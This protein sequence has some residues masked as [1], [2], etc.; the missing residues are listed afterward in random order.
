MIN[1]SSNNNYSLADIEKYLQ[2][3]MSAAEMHELEKAALQDAFLADAI[4]GYK[5]IS[6]QQSHQHLQ[7]IETLIIGTKEETKVIP[8]QSSNNHVWKIA[9]AVIAVALVGI[10]FWLTNS[11]QPNKNS[12]AVAKSAIQTTTDSS[13]IKSDTVQPIIATLSLSKKV[14]IAK[15]KVVDDQLNEL[16]KEKTEEATSLKKQAVSG[17]IILTDSISYL[18][19]AVAA[20]EIESEKPTGSLTID[21]AL[22]GK[23]AGVQINNK[24]KSKDLVIR[25]TSILSAGKNP[26]YIIDGQLYDNIPETLNTS[27]FKKIEVLNDAGTAALYGSRAANGVM[28]ITTNEKNKNIFGRITDTKGNPVSYASLLYKKD[29]AIATDA[30]GYFSINT[31]DTVL[32][33][34]ASA[35][36]YTA[37]NTQLANNRFNKIV[38]KENE[39]ALDEVVVVGYGT[40]KKMSL[41]GSVAAVNVNTDTLMPEGG[42]NNYKNYLTAKIT[43]NA[44]GKKVSGDI[45]FEFKIDSKGFAV[46]VNIL[47]SPDSSI[48]KQL[49]DAIK[50]GPK[51]YTANKKLKKQKAVIKL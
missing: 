27:A 33:L 12:V 50:Q 38:L 48:N 39:N 9:A 14:S 8:I 44:A 7:E 6:L 45:V 32:N 25:G 43:A 36:G 31:R 19:S 4:E 20:K 3:K 40:Q 23:V 11:N 37:A 30:N 21:Q 41:T 35:V 10:V 15:N 49:I 2:G 5:D 22:A 26:L 46:K 13:A 16:S 24:N 51:W 42:W 1:S 29:K 28:L 34:T 18:N 47:N 17:S